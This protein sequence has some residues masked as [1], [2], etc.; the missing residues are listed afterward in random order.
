MRVTH[1]HTSA[2]IIGFVVMMALG[3]DGS[4]GPV[5]A[6]TT[7]AIHIKV[8][9]EGAN[10][11]LDTDGYGITVD[12]RFWAI[13]IYG[14]LTIDHL[15]PTT[16]FVNLSGLASNCSVAASNERWVDVVAGGLAELTYTVTCDPMPTDGDCGWDCYI[17]SQSIR[18]SADDIVSASSRVFK[19]DRVP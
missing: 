5:T 16:H 12:G 9:T 11:D 2:T 3:C 17:W 14:A 8:F 1:H 13:G 19:P 18:P 15:A 6:P 7:G 4:T 10:L